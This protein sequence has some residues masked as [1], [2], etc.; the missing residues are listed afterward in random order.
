[1]CRRYS[2]WRLQQYTVK[3]E[4]FPEIKHL[5][6]LAHHRTLIEPDRALCHFALGRIFDVTEKYENAFT[7]YEKANSLC[8]K[9][10]PFDEDHLIQT[11]QPDNST[12]YK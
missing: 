11:D 4:L 12:V 10:H 8:A 5:Q 7:H 2:I 3:D 1:M 9:G 6:E